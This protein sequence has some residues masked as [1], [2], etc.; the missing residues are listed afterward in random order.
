MNFFKGFFTHA[1]DWQKEQAYHIEARRLHQRALH[2]PGIVTGELEDLRIS[3]TAEGA[4]LVQSG[5]AIDGQGRE[6]YLP[7]PA[8]LS[9]APE[10]YQSLDTVYIYIAYGEEAVDRRTNHLNPEYTGY[11]FFMERPKVGWAKEP[12]DNRDR[13]ELARV[14]VQRGGRITQDR[15]DRSHVLYAGKSGPAGHLVQEG[16]IQVDAS[17][18]SSFSA[19]DANALIESFSSTQPPETALYLANVFPIEGNGS[20]RIHWRIESLMTEH[21]RIEYRLYVK[22]FGSK[23][24]DVR[25]LVYRLRL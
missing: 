16:K 20:P 15:I 1:E 23:S 8:A 19:D 14:T 9:I 2:S 24:V 3:V 25:Y 6:L 13:I 4:I 11:A 22:N 12:P 17:K 5:C 18:D 21:N 10:E 7:E